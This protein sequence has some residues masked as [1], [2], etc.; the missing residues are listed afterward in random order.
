MLLSPDDADLFFRLHKALMAFINKRLGVVASDPLIVR[1]QP[2]FPPEQRLLIRKALLKKMGLIDR[3]VEENPEGLGDEELSIV[4]SWKHTVAGSFIVTQQLKKH[5]VFLSTSDPPVAYG[6]LGL[7]DR[8]G[9]LAG[10]CPTMVDAALLPFKGQI[11]HDGVLQGYNVAFGSG[12]RASLKESY[13]EAKDRRGI[14][15]S[16]PMKNTAPPL[17]VQR[18]TTKGTKKQTVLGRW[19]IIE[20]ELWDQEFVDA[21]VEGYIHFD[22]VGG[23]EFQFGYVWGRM[24]CEL[25]E[26]GGRPGIEWTWEGSEEM[27]RASGRGWAVLKEEGVLQGKLFFHV[28]DA[29][30]FIATR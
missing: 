25:T 6:V 10:P 29:S 14:V 22:N 21:E 23:G 17:R 28:G 5:A 19:R 7:S 13:R 24:T 30:K 20:M 12:I 16:L 1:G 27:D 11:V 18:R 2:T 15:T 4:A 9:D 26:R 3:F 8:I